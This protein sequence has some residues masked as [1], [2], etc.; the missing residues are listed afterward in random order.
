MIEPDDSTNAPH[1]TESDVEQHFI[2]DLL[3]NP[4]PLGLGYP[5][6]SIRT[7]HEIRQLTIGKGKQAKLHYP[8]Y[9]LVVRRYP[10]AVLEAKRPGEDLEEALRE[11]RLYAHEL[12][13]RFDAGCNPVEHVAATDG[14]RLIWGRWDSELATGLIWRAEADP[15]FLNFAAWIEVC[16]YEAAK[17]RIEALIQR[18]KPANYFWPLGYLGGAAKRAEELPQ[19]GFG[20]TIALDYRYLFNPTTLEERAVIAKEAYVPSSARDRYIEPIDK[21]IRAALPPSETQATA[22]EDLGD[23]KELIQA[24][25]HRTDLDH[26]V[27][28]IVGG[29]GMGKSTFIDYVREVKLPRDLRRSTVWVHLNMNEAPVSAELIYDWIMAEIIHK[30]EA[31]RT[32]LDFEEISQIEK[33]LSVEVKRLEKGVLQLLKDQPDQYARERFQEIKQLLENK[34]TYLNALVRYICGN[35]RTRLVL[36][37]DNSDKRIRD[38]QLLLFEVAQ[39]LQKELRCLIILP[40]RDETY[41]NHRNEPPLDTVIKDL[42]FRIEPPM[43]QEVLRRRINLALRSIDAD[44]NF[45]YKLSNGMRVTYSGR[46]QAAFL[47]S[48]LTSVHEHDRFVRR[49]LT[50]LAGRDIR[51]AIEL[52]LDFCKSGHISEELLT[53][54]R[55]SEGKEPLPFDVVANVLLRGTRRYYSSKESHLKNILACSPDDPAPNYF[56]RFAALKWL[57]FHLHTKGPTGLTG[58]HQAQALV[59]DLVLAGYD[60]EAVKRELLTLLAAFCIVAEHLRDDSMH[61]TDLIKL[62]AAGWAHLDMLTTLHYHATVAE[63]TYYDTEKPAREVAARIGSPHHY[64]TITMAEN[65]QTFLDYLAGWQEKQIRPTEDLLVTDRVSYLRTG[66]EVL[67]AA[68]KGLRN[69]QEEHDWDFAARKLERGQICEGMVVRTLPVGFLVYL[70]DSITGL[71]HFSKI[72]TDIWDRRESLDGAILRVRVARVDAKQKRVALDVLDVALT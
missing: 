17:C 9:A 31:S 48:I 58:Y 22:L 2:L 63:D 40:L 41:D 61:G 10:V 18:S 7:K 67:D 28:I 8:D 42:V 29:V 32:D 21:I 57:E 5:A 53:G 16:N 35:A 25:R 44:R 19:N 43:F 60:G 3:K 62:T 24:M 11:A 65:A 59:S 64:E 50:G 13:T 14:E 49:L 54:I 6:D 12:N 20:T 70:N 68:R 66:D 55:L 46:D 4:V 30:L 36:V 33:V 71:A 27:L 26:Q 69:F 51:R 45:E 15:S 34:R 72:P 47:R 39:W 37:F 52:F 23:P 56:V 38:Q 1:V